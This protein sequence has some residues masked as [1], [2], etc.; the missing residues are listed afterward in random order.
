MTVLNSSCTDR[1]SENC[2]LFHLNCT[3]RFIV[4]MTRLALNRIARERGVE[5]RLATS[6]WA[7]K[8]SANAC[9]SVRGQQ[10]AAAMGHIARFLAHPGRILRTALNTPPVR[11]PHQSH[12]AR[13]F[14]F[15]RAIVCPGLSKVPRLRKAKGRRVHNSFLA[16]LKKKSFPS[17][18]GIPTQAR[19]NKYTVRRR[20]PR[21]ATTTSVVLIAPRRHHHV[22]TTNR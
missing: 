19:V 14:C 10:G 12:A 20:N 13:H 4:T 6:L 3:M 2:E 16:R 7:G 21:L 11:R 22:A 18:I 17:S 1:H 5:T 15:S 8:S 9:A